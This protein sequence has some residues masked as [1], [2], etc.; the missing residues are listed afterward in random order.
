MCDAAKNQ[1][2]DLSQT[3]T[4]LL[5]GRAATSLLMSDAMM[6]RTGSIQWVEDVIAE[7][8]LYDENESRPTQRYVKRLLTR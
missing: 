4:P 8:D 6:L 7:F 5:V 1:D 3:Q 2:I